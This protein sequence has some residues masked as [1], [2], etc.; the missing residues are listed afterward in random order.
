[1]VATKK[2]LSTMEAKMEGVGG[3]TEATEAVRDFCEEHDGSVDFSGVRNASVPLPPPDPGHEHA[4]HHKQLPLLRSIYQ[5]C[6][7]HP[8]LGLYQYW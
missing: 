3:T 6:I 1:M 7:T 5:R 2:A 8:Q 4:I